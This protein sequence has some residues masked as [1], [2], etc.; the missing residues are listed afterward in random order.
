MQRLFWRTL[1]AIAF[2]VAY[3]F[4]FQRWLGPLV[5]VFLA[6]V[7][8]V[9]FT[10]I[11]IDAAAEFGWSLKVLA[12]DRLGGQH[13]QFQNHTIDVI[14][15]ADHCR[16]IATDT[17]RKIVGQLAS[18][19]ALAQLFPVGHQLMGKRQ[20]GHL[21]DDALIAHLSQA[22]APQAIKFK[23]WAERNIAYPARTTRQRKGITVPA[24]NS[25]I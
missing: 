6:V 4:L 7:V 12:F 3:F 25:E 2:C 9:A 21:R 11:L 10:R 24:P 13:F 19:Y 16:W 22:T 20:K 17:V 5:W 18:D 15:D 14:E 23:N 8:G 1:G